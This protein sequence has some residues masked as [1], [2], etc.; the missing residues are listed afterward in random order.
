MAAGAVIGGVAGVLGAGDED[1]DA[2][3]M[4]K[5]QL[6]QMRSDFYTGSNQKAR[7]GVK[8]LAKTLMT[9][10]IGVT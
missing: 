8:G 4:A 1:K 2:E 6:M 7:R 5:M 10:L 9:P 3:E